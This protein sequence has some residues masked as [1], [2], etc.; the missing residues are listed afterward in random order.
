MKHFQT[1][2]K[3]FY[4]G[5]GIAA[6]CSILAV[7]PP[8]TRHSFLGAL[9]FAV[10]ALGGSLATTKFTYAKLEKD[11]LRVVRVFFFRHTI[12]V[13]RIKRI[14]Y[15][16]TWRFQG[17]LRSIYIHYE[18]G[19]APYTELPNSQYP[20]FTLAN[21]VKELSKLNPRIE[22]DEP[23]KELLKSRETFA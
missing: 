3:V 4:I 13:M 6:L 14:R 16:P 10:L 5:V 12:M 22:L 20:E 11:I 9:Y 2:Q 1:D 8:I 15:V 17:K 18:G 19:W 7:L 23:A 21:L